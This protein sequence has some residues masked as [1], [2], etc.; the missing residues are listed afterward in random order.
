M[1]Y[2]TQEEVIQNNLDLHEELFDLMDRNDTEK[3]QREDRQAFQ[4]F[5]AAHPEL[6]TYAGNIVEQAALNLISSIAKQSHLRQSLKK[7]LTQM[8]NELRLPTDGPLEELLLQQVVLCWLRYGS[9]EHSY[10]VITTEGGTYERLRY[11][12]QRLNAA[13]RRYLRALETLAR[14]RKLQ[15]P[16]IQVNIGG[17]QVN[18]VNI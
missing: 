7:G 17:Q 13:Q 9:V 12:E 5:L 3:P 8:P 2:L 10:T 1:L 4:Q 18:Q 6:W 15:L 14:I 11:W 16:P